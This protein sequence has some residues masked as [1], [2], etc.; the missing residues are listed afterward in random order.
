MKIIQ[1]KL[2]FM[3][4]SPTVKVVFYRNVVVKITD[5]PRFPTPDVSMLEASA[6]V[7]ALEKAIIAAS[8]GGRTS[9]SVMHDQEKLTDTVFRN[10][11]AYVDRMAA[12]DE[13]TI[14]SSGFHCSKQPI[15]SPKAILTM[16]DGAHSGSVKFIGK[17]IPNAGA[18]HYQMC[19]GSIPLTED[20]WILCGVSTSASF[21]LSGL[22]VM[23][24]YYFRIAAIT[25]DGLTDY[26][27]PV[28]KVIV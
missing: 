28:S 25:P 26:S 15:Y 14:L 17:A 18:Y 21:E 22:E 3:Q 27:E 2:D 5:N 10:L 11:T 6:A 4:Y 12:G 1:T 9:I 13:S 20:G 7:D 24:L 23:C 19:K 8:D 16:I